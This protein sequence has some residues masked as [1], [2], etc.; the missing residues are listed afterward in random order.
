M[1]NVTIHRVSVPSIECTIIYPLSILPYTCIYTIHLS[2]LSYIH[3]VLVL[4]SIEFILCVGGC[5]CVCIC[6]YMQVVITAYVLFCH[7][8]VQTLCVSLFIING[9]LHVC[10]V[11]AIDSLDWEAC[12]TS[13]IW[14][15]SLTLCL[16]HFL[17]F[18]PRLYVCL[19]LY[20]STCVACV[21]VDILC[22]E[23]PVI[24]D[25]SLLV[26]VR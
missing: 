6:V 4:P 2:I 1:K 17:L 21:L 26:Q 9:S 8:I 18:V 3:W 10:V 22:Q 19:P 23:I 11:A 24:P 5:V 14:S 25:K 7:F 16:P 15:L 12:N 20:A 13:I